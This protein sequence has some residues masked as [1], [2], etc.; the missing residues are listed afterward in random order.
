MAEAFTG[1]IW[2]LINV[3]VAL[4]N[5]PN[6]LGAKPPSA[7]DSVREPKPA[8]LIAR[9]WARPQEP[10]FPAISSPAPP[11][12]PEVGSV[13]VA[14]PVQPAPDAG[15]VGSGG[16]ATLAA[17]T[18]PSPPPHPAVLAVVPLGEP[19]YP[20]A[21]ARTTRAKGFFEPLAPDLYRPVG[22]AGARVAPSVPRLLGR[23][24]HPAPLSEPMPPWYHEENGPGA[25]NTEAAD[26]E[27]RL[28]TERAHR[29]RS[30]SVLQRTERYAPMNHDDL[31]R[32]HW[33]T[34]QALLLQAV[35]LA[36]GDTLEETQREPFL[37]IVRDHYLRTAS[38]FPT[39]LS[40]SVRDKAWDG[41]QTSVRQSRPS[42]DFQY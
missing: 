41:F 30:S 2:I 23:R 6:S 1:G 22:L 19:A 31:A 13:A 15:M 14:Q 28:Q 39:G 10:P 25:T 12:L 21:P 37:T 5:V 4:L 11:L 16:T 24:D 32:R 36:L 27:T 26:S 20:D 17:R 40:T 3:L 18:E 33:L 35:A 8:E 42:T 9:R 7:I 29:T 38:Q 34:A